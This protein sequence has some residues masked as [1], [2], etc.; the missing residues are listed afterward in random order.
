M[1]GWRTVA[2]VGVTVLILSIIAVGALMDDG[3]GADSDEMS[4]EEIDA[5]VADAVDDLTSMDQ[6]RES[7]CPKRDGMRTMCPNKRIARHVRGCISDTPNATGRSHCR[8]PEILQE[9]FRNEDNCTGAYNTPDCV[10][11]WDRYQDCE[12]EQIGPGPGDNCMEQV[13][14][15]REAELRSAD[16]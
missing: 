9:R 4:P 6:L 15:E 14:A 8:N 3:G 12:A 10:T 5:W 13:H 16:L 11:V 1:S 2:A 7:A